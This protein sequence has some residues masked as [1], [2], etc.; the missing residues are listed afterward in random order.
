MILVF[1]AFLGLIFGSFFNV[2]ILRTH[3]RETL[4]GR[5]KCF[6]CQKILHWFEMVP[7]ASFL[8]QGGRCRSC[9]LKI[10]RQYPLVEIASALIFVCSGIKAAN[11]VEFLFLAAAGSALLII[12]VYDL[13]YLEIPD[14]FIFFPLVILLILGWSGGA[15]FYFLSFLGALA[16][17]GFFGLQFL[18]SRGRWIG[19][20]DITLG[21]LLGVILGWPKILLALFLSYVGGALISLLLIGLKKKNWKSQMPFG[22]FLAPAAWLVLFLGDKMIAWYLHLFL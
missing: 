9:G 7:L 1:Y 11:W 21:L 5:S 22:V 16:A 10:S 17:A 8:F 4:G 2:V 13:K 20:G 18:I 3:G 19:A 15:K 6:F 14:G 12:F